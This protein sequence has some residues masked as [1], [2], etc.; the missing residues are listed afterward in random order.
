MKKEIVYEENEWG[1]YKVIKQSNGVNVRLH[2]ETSEAYKQK[3]GLKAEQM[4]IEDDERKEKERK[5]K[6]IKDRLRKKAL[7][8]LKEEGLLPSDYE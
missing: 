3:M 2:R 7:E 4:R 1:K 6:L 5:E 8:E